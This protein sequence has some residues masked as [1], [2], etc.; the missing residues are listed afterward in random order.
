MVTLIMLVVAYGIVILTVLS[1]SA[2][3]TNGLVRVCRRPRELNLCRI[4]T[5]VDRKRR[6][7]PGA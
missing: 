3:S 6:R 2:I 7:R 5:R 4:R 1:I